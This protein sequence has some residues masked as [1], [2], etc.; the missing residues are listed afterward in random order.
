MFQK[1]PHTFLENIIFFKVLGVGVGLKGVGLRL[2]MPYIQIKETCCASEMACAV[3]AAALLG[4][5]M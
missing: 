2:Q 4:G 3:A 5:A 1:K